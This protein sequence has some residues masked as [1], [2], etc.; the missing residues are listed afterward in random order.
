MQCKDS[1]THSFSQPFIGQLNSHSPFSLICS[2]TFLFT[3]IAI[4]CHALVYSFCHLIT[5]CTASK[6]YC[7]PYHLEWAHFQFHISHD[8][9]LSFKA[10][11]ACAFESTHQCIKLTQAFYDCCISLYLKKHTLYSVSVKQFHSEIPWGWI[12]W[13]S[14][15]KHSWVEPK[16]MSTPS[17][18]SYDLRS[19]SKTLIQ[20]LT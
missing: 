2:F 6:L 19:V 10:I 17:E 7:F 3:Q 13:D 20:I 9:K 8:L 16:C 5:H 12:D 15:I 18:S 11:T 14:E 1:V 4:I